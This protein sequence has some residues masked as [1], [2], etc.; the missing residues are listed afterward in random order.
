MSQR[1]LIQAAKEIGIQVIKAK[2][3]GDAQ[4][5]AIHL[6]NPTTD[7]LLDAINTAEKDMFPAIV[8]HNNATWKPLYQGQAA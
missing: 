3:S 7:D 6:L 5:V 2:H 8:I 1:K 4:R